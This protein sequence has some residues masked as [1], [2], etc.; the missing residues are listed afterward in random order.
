MNRFIRYLI[1]LTLS[2][3]SQLA[4]ASVNTTTD[5]E[6]WELAGKL[7]NERIEKNN[8][9]KALGLQDQMSFVIDMYEIL[10][11]KDN[12]FIKD[13]TSLN[14]KL[15]A[16]YKSG[17]STEGQ[18]EAYII[19]M[20][21]VLDRIVQG[22]DVDKEN[23]QLSEAGERGIGLEH[24][25]SIKPEFQNSSI[26]VL[27]LNGAVQ[28]NPIG[29]EQFQT[30][31]FPYVYGSSALL[32]YLRFNL[33]SGWLDKYAQLSVSDNEREAY[34]QKT[35]DK[36]IEVVQK[37]P[38]GLGS[39][40]L[41]R[42]FKEGINGDQYSDDPVK[43]M[44]INDILNELD[45]LNP[46][47]DQD[48]GIT[49]VD[50]LNSIEK[51]F[52]L[53][54]QEITEEN[55][56][57]YLAYLRFNERGADAADRD[58][59]KLTDDEALRGYCRLL[60]LRFSQ[61][62][63][64]QSREKLLRAW[65][66]ADQL[67]DNGW[68]GY[69]ETKVIELI[70]KTTLQDTENLL[71]LFRENNCEM[72]LAFYSDLDDFGGSD[73]NSLFIEELL[74]V[75]NFSISTHFQN[76]S[77]E[78]QWQKLFNLVNEK[79]IKLIV[80]KQVG[81]SAGLTFNSISFSET[82]TK[83][84]QLTNKFCIV[85][86]HY[87]E[88]EGSSIYYCDEIRIEEGTGTVSPL[89]YVAIITT[90][91]FPILNPE[92]F[93][94][95]PFQ[96]EI[97]PAIKFKYDGKE[98]TV[99]SVQ[100]FGG[101]VLTA[102]SFAVPGLVLYRAIQ[103][104]NILVASFAGLELAA[105]GATEI[106]SSE[107]FHTA[108]I[109]SGRSEETFKSI[110]AVIV[111]LSFIQLNTSA[112]DNIWNASRTNTIADNITQVSRTQLT[113]KNISEYID[114]VADAERN[115]LL[116][117]QQMEVLKNQTSYLKRELAREGRILAK[118]GD[119]IIDVA[120]ATEKQL[121]DVFARISKDP[122]SDYTPNTIEHKADR[123]AQYKADKGAAAK[124]YD[125]WSNLY[126]ANMNKANV[127]RQIEIDYMNSI[128]W[129]KHQVTVKAGNQTRRLDIADETLKKAVEIKSYETGK[130]YATEIIRG[131]VSADKFLVEMQNWKIE[132]VFKGCEP[133]QPLRELLEEADIIIK[134]IP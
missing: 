89:E 110:Q 55:L 71:A 64:W 50:E 23:T 43:S 83:E 100:A 32:Q 35:T 77:E 123:W 132:W 117:S 41:A 5:N 106:A 48:Y 91:E 131:E 85:R 70:S 36:Y 66:K 53:K 104:R 124:D 114:F 103:A 86:K 44:L 29:S 122:P 31:N 42:K 126:N 49:R 4:I 130:V 125:A 97:V 38:G 56:R 133:S 102:A 105:A 20:L 28:E 129:G 60:P 19:I 3:T 15:S 1:L 33:F 62:L 17:L 79:K 75:V 58:I 111:A 21:P 52:Y 76:L 101:V 7:L 39:S 61:G 8:E 73:N 109:S 27:M 54:R 108:I 88:R 2:F 22:V 80:L 99:K 127:A 14:L 92:A 84:Y 26:A 65:A 98:Q 74:R 13:K 107:A 51:I 82:S 118:G 72:L 120:R 87:S 37:K 45:K 94:N 6:V 95:T 121:D 30:L 10:N 46:V 63:S 69:D 25:I 113:D 81:L 134:V 78:A 112:V 40:F 47:L 67:A 9:L 90:S 16:V 59:E 57:N 96:V 115:N 24:K 11:G 18:I 93:F 68:Q 34:L 128:G 116:P 119:E 12:F